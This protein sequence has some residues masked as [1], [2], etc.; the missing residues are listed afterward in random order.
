MR[1][2]QKETTKKVRLQMVSEYM[3]SQ[4]GNTSRLNKK[5]IYEVAD[6]FCVSP[7]TVRFAINQFTKTTRVLD[8]EGSL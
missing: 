8:L 1:D 5:A 6:K 3:K 7:F 4:E 2:R